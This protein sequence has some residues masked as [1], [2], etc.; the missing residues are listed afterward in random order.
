MDELQIATKQEQRWEVPFEFE[1]LQHIRGTLGAI[2]G[3]A[4]PDHVL[5]D[6]QSTSVLRD[7]VIDRQFFL[8][9][10]VAAG[11]GRLIFNRSSS[12]DRAYA[13]RPVSKSLRSLVQ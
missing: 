7:H 6:I 4:R 3:A 9:A 1:P 8:R 13:L 11:L 2:T 5:P 12:R 10:A